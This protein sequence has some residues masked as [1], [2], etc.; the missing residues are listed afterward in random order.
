MKEF[1]EWRLFHVTIVQSDSDDPRLAGNLCGGEYNIPIL[2]GEL[3][4]VVVVLVC[5]VGLE[6]HF[7]GISTG[8]NRTRSFSTHFAAL[9]ILAA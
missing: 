7:H 8:I 4:V 6:L 3:K 5:F 1:P 2:P 9:A